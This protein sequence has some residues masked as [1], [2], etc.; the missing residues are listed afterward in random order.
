MSREVL[1]D[2]IPSRVMPPLQTRLLGDIVPQAVNDIFRVSLVGRGVAGIHVN[3]FHV[4]QTIVV[5]G[6]PLAQVS[7]AFAPALVEYMACFPTTFTLEEIGVAQV[8]VGQ[9]GLPVA[10]FPQSQLGTRTPAEFLPFQSAAVV[11]IKG[12]GGGRRG[13]GRM[14]FGYTFESDQANGLWLAGVTDKYGTFIDALADAY[15]GESTDFELGVFSTVGNVFSAYVS[16][17]ARQ[18]VY[19]QRRRRLGA[20]A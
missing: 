5:G 13:T 15:N 4:R 6:D 14:Y 3:T 7:A 2:N 1:K 16:N 9:T 12:A 10:H 17:V 8:I 19:T 20:G 11:T 18:A